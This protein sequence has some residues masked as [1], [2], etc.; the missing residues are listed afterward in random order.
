MF[1]IIGTNVNQYHLRTDNLFRIVYPNYAKKLD[2]F[3]SIS[4]GQ[5]EYKNKDSIDE[6]E[7]FIL[8]H[9]QLDP[10]TG[11]GTLYYTLKYNKSI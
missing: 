7:I 2:L 11:G 8:E 5:K 10:K 3:E 4:S 6:N 1:P 9:S